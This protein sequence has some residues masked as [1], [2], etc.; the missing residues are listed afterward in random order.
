MTWTYGLAILSIIGTVA[1]IYK[2]RWCFAVWLLTN[3][4]WCIYDACIG[5]YAQSGLFAVYAGLA[6]MGLV[7][8]RKK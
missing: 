3:T 8:W 6:V 1:N 2:K 4:T 7:Q 5:E